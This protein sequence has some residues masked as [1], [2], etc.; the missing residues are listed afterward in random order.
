MIKV[1][2]IKMV[3]LRE[4]NI[5]NKERCIY[6]D[7]DSECISKKMREIQMNILL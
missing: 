3:K 4:F 2:V 1:Y 7:N 6:D 5:N